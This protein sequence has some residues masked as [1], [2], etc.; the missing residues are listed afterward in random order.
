MFSIRASSLT[1]YYDCSRR[2]ATKIFRDQIGAAGYQLATLRKMIGAAIGT[3]AHAAM[4]YT[5]REKMKSGGLGFN[6]EA[7]ARAIDALQEAVN[8]GVTYDFK[9]AQTLKGAQEQVLRKV[10]EI[11]TAIA[12]QLRPLDVE[13]QLRAEYRGIEVTGTLDIREKEGPAD[14]KSGK[15]KRQNGP[16]YGLY[17]MLADTHYEKST[18]IREIYLATAPLDKPQ[19]KAEFA[20]YN[21]EDSARFARSMLDN[22]IDDHAKFENTGGDRFS[23]RAN[24]ASLLCGPKYCPAYGTTFCKEHLNKEK[25]Y[26]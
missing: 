11:R 19:P 6:D 5:L 7:E 15:F 26:G 24:P 21:V 8:E 2:A 23:F 17:G 16:Q 25:V 14:L 1:D 22:I 3:G 18:R 9:V 4:E 10:K 13:I 20:D 12:P